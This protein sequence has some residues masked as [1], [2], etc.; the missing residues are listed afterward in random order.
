M[1]KHTLRLLG[2]STGTVRVPAEALIEAT[3]PDVKSGRPHD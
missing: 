3:V 2:G 1:K